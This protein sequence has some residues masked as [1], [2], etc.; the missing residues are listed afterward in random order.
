MNK[1]NLTEEQRKSIAR[2]KTWIEDVHCLECGY[3]GTMG[4]VEK[5]YPWYFKTWFIIII[6][7]LGSIYYGSGILIA[8]IMFIFRDPRYILECPNCRQKL[9]YK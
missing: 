3:I 5:L 6:A 9:N 4:I 8:I 1:D 2:Y 7:L